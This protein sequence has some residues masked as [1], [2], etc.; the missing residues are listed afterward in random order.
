MVALL[1]PIRDRVKLAETKNRTI[2]EIVCEFR[3]R[4]RTLSIALGAEDDA[5]SRPLLMEES[6]KHYGAYQVSSGSSND[7]VTI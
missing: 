6:D 3:Q 7:I 2:E 1:Q 5:E 4:K